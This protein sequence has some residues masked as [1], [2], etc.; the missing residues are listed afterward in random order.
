[1]RENG[2]LFH[3]RY[4]AKSEEEEGAWGLASHGDAQVGVLTAVFSW[5]TIGGAT[6]DKGPFKRLQSIG[7]SIDTFALLAV[8]LASL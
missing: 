7:H 4:G 3:L 5:A 2:H 1:V 6:T 8:P